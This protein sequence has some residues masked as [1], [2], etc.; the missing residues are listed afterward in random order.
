MKG[1]RT[2]HVKYKSGK[3]IKAQEFN[4]SDIQRMLSNIAHI[5]NICFDECE[6]NGKHEGIVSEDRFV[7]LQE[8]LAAQKERPHRGDLY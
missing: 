6:C 7:Q 1:Y 5:G 2:K 4:R 8:L 3:E